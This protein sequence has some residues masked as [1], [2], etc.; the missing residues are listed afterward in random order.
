MSRAANRHNFLSARLLAAALLAMAGPAFTREEVNKHGNLPPNTVTPSGIPVE[1]NALF[2]FDMR[3]N[4]DQLDQAAAIV[5]DAGYRCDSISGFSAH[6]ISGFS[7]Q[8][9]DSGY[10]L[11][12]N[13]FSYSYDIDIDKEDGRWVVS[14]IL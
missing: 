5:R 12:C 8:L 11:V 9:F 3:R 7:T 13:R 1:N 10:Q 2:S 4:L 14:V 6:S